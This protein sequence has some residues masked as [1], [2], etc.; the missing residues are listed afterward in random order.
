MAVGVVQQTVNQA[1]SIAGTL[2]SLS[3][4]REGQSTQTKVIES[5]KNELKEKQKQIDIIPIR[6][7]VSKIQYSDHLRKLIEDPEEKTHNLEED[8]FEEYSKEYERLGNK[9]IDPRYVAQNVANDI[10]NRYKQINEAGFNAG[11]DEAKSGYLPEI[12]K[13]NSEKADLE[14]QLA[15]DR[16]L[17]EAATDAANAWRSKYYRGINRQDEMANRSLLNAQIKKQRGARYR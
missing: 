6:E 12:D 9:D 5:L 15:Q 2:F 7:E 17:Q 11:F 14:T 10:R 16:A 1:F 4:L 13:L 8:L 3:G